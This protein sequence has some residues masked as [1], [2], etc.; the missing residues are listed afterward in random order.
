LCINKRTQVPL[1][2]DCV[3]F[4]YAKSKLQIALIK[5][6]KPPF[7]GKWALPGGFLIGDETLEEAAFRELK[8]ETGLQN[9]YL[10]QFHVFSAPQR[11]PRGRVVTAGFFALI[12]SE[13]LK[14]IATEDALEAVWWE[15]DKLPPLAFD[16]ETIFTMGFAALKRA[17]L[18][19]PLVFELLGKKFTLT[20]LQTLYEQI[21]AQTI[22][23]R[24]FRKKILKSA[25]VKATKAVTKKARHRPAL[26]YQYNTKGKS[27]EKLFQQSLF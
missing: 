13:N 18:L 9:I 25:L 16:H 21:F 24:N 7:V 15:I 2:I 27:W 3:I 12:S 17:I 8:E 1:S 11:D 22:D 23:K 10:E 26:L 5:R 19:R 6:K 20:E 14:L 4:G